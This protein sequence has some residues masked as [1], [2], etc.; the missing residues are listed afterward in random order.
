MHQVRRLVQIRNRGR[1]GHLEAQQPARQVEAGEQLAQKI[2]EAR[3]VDADPRQIDGVERAAQRRRLARQRAALAL[4]MQVF[5]ERADDPALDRGQQVV[6]LRRRHE[7]ARRHQVAVLID[8]A[9]EDLVMRLVA[10]IAAECNDFLPVEAEIAEFERVI[11]LRDEPQ[12][13][14]LPRARARASCGEPGRDRALCFSPRNRSR[15]RWRAHGSRSPRRRPQP[16]PR[17]RRRRKS[18]PAE[19]NRKSRTASRNPFAIRTAWI[20]RTRFEQHAEF[21]A[22]EPR[23]RVAGRACARRA[24]RWSVAAAARRRRRGRR[25]RLRS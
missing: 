21:I 18:C 5:D 6:A 1:F 20:E 19:M 15:P 13:G 10:G 2:D 12:I 24:S 8:H 17:S 3:I 11:D 9:H 7:A 4:A 23:Q 14:V 25:C 22:A 16:V